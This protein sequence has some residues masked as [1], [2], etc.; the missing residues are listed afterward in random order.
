VLVALDAEFV[1][2]CATAIDPAGRLLRAPPVQAF[3]TIR[4]ETQLQA[5]RSGKPASA[6]LQ[7]V[8]F[9]HAE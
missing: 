1:K 4:S 8:N 3:Y 6:T 5:A 2:M 9:V 7:G